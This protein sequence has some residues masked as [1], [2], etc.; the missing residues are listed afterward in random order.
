[1]AS[2]EVLEAFAEHREASTEQSE[3]SHEGQQAVFLMEATS[4]NGAGSDQENRSDGSGG[5]ET[6][7]HNGGRV[8]IGAEATLGGIIYDF[9]KLW[10]Y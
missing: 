4:E 9:G 8:K 5:N 10:G 7:F 6:A 1:M 3:E 2:Y